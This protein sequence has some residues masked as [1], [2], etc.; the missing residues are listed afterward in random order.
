MIEEPANPPADERPSI[1]ER[2][3]AFALARLGRYENVPVVGLAVDLLRRD[4]ESAGALA[5]SALAFRLFTFF[6]P[7]LLLLVGVASFA[8][9]FVSAQQVN[10]G[11][12][13]SGSL[14][15]QMRSAFAQSG[16]TPVLITLLGFIGLLSAGRS[17]SRAL[18][19]I[20][21]SA[22]RLS[23]SGK[24]SMRVVGAIAGLA[25]GMGMVSILTNRVR[26]DLGLGAAALS[27]GP[28]FAIYTAA[29]LVTLLLLP[30]NTE[31]PGAVLPGAILTGGVLT[32]MQAVSQF[33]LPDRFNRARELYGAIGVTV[34]TLGWF[35][36]LGRSIV[37]AI[38]LNP[39]V[40]DR[41]GSVSTV[42][43]SLPLLRALPRRSERLRRFFD[44]DDPPAPL[45]PHEATGTNGGRRG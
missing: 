44:L 24:S 13:V 37:I 1:V 35:F 42:V 26:N 29:W 27:M 25:A 6:V 8:S 19:S 31:D 16:R 45:L 40:Y 39:V 3:T 30:R 15:E 36:I 41:Y 11:L 10:H 2:A 32:A 38:E 33:Y 17:L 43:F 23:M 14:A 20:S 21:N 34:V 4:S 18:V 12:G 9:G 5:G 28:T 7:L 22:W